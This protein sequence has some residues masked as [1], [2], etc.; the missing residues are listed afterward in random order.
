M[1]LKSPA[2]L[3]G[4]VLLI[5]AAPPVPTPPRLDRHGNPLPPGAL[6]RMGRSH[7]LQVRNVEAVAFSP[8]GKLLAVANGSVTLW[9]AS[10]GRKVRTLAV[11]DPSESAVSKLVFSSDSK[12]LAGVGDV[13]RLWEVAAGKEIR[14]FD[15]RDNC[16]RPSAVAFSPDGRKLAVATATETFARGFSILLFEVGTWRKIRRLRVP[17]NWVDDLAFT[18]DGKRLAALNSGVARRVRQANTMSGFVTLWDVAGGKELVSRTDICPGTLSPDGRWY[19]VKAKTGRVE[20]HDLAENRRLRTL[21]SRDPIQVFS[22]DGKFLADI[23]DRPTVRVWEVATGNRVRQ[24]SGDPSRA[25]RPPIEPLWF[26]LAFSTDGKRLA[27]GAV[28]SSYDNDPWDGVRLWD[29]DHGVELLPAEGHLAP[30]TCLALSTD[31]KFLASG[32]RDRTVCLWE[33]ATGKQLRRFVGHTGPIETV[34]LSSTGRLAASSHK[35]TVRLWDTATGREVLCIDIARDRVLS[36]C[37]LPNEKRLQIYDRNGLVRRYDIGSGK[38]VDQF[39]DRKDGCSTLLLGPDGLASGESDRSA[40]VQQLL[41]RS[42]PDKGAR[43]GR[44]NLRTARLSADGRLLVLCEG[45]E[46][47]RHSLFHVWEVATGGL[48]CDS[49]RDLCGS[50]APVFSADGWGLFTAGVEGGVRAWD[51]RSG[52]PAGDFVTGPSEILALAL[53]PDGTRLASGAAD[54]T[55][56]IW[57]V[58]GLFRSPHRPPPSDPE[59]ARLWSCLGEAVARRAYRSMDRLSGSPEQVVPF[60]AAKLKA[61]AA[62]GPDAIRKLIADLDDESFAVRQRAVAELERLAP[63]VAPAL[64]RAVEKPASLESGKRVEKILRTLEAPRTN[65]GQL[66]ILRGISVLE[67]IGTAEARRALR[68]LANA[69][70]DTFQGLEAEAALMR[71]APRP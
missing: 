12:C 4:C 17:G 53:S 28:E 47:S 62:P 22:A 71:L 24:I 9:D 49:G 68:D 54:T 11:P 63:V 38:L 33:T 23:D 36:L 52:N 64:R 34:A 20:I 5:A 13:V 46:R 15:Y 21:E 55:V 29:L 48:I 1:S 25:C 2:L 69:A 41:P 43:W 58:K 37:F 44:D 16:A 27:T 67:R 45:R 66:Q 60:L 35:G 70:P 65:R 31:N 7:V 50:C 6:A 10:S 56:L 3:L 42:L 32:S 39:H 30:V 51:L 8:D 14:I 40:D 18:A 57:D 61:F 19:T 59:L 26:P